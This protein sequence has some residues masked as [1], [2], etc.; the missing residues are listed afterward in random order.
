MANGQIPDYLF[1][2][3][4]MIQLFPCIQP[5]LILINICAEYEKRLSYRPILPIHRIFR[6]WPFVSAA[7]HFYTGPCRTA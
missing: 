1:N 5:L 3:W 7:E 2:F 6:I 4:R